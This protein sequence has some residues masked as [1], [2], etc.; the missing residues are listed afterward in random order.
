MKVSHF[1]FPSTGWF[2]ELSPETPSF[3]QTLILGLGQE[4]GEVGHTPRATPPEG[5]S[6]LDYLGR[7][8]GQGLYFRLTPPLYPTLILLVD[9]WIMEVIGCIVPYL[10]LS[11]TRTIVIG[12]QHMETSLVVGSLGSLPVE[13]SK[14]GIGMVRAQKLHIHY[15]PYLWE[16]YFGVISLHNIRE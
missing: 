9:F 4:V 12:S 11:Q 7:L 8:K 5:V 16:L 1:C 2:I 3:V 10:V 15:L 13:Y 14:V 6:C